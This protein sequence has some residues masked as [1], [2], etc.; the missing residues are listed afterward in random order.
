MTTV[1]FKD[2]EHVV[3]EEAEIVYLVARNWSGAVSA[4]HWTNKYYPG[5][6]TELVTQERLDQKKEEQK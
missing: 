3:D 2:R 6:K 1:N 4:P 5:Y